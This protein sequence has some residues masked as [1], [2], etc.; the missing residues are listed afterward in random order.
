MGAPPHTTPP[1]PARRQ[2]SSAAHSRRPWSIDDL[3]VIAFALLGFGGGV[4]L[5]HFMTM[6]AITTS[7]LLA[8][9]L[10]ALTYR[11]LGGIQ[12]ASITIGSLKLGGALAALVGIAMLINHTM[13]AETTPPPAPVVPSPLHKAYHVTGTVVDDKG[14]QVTNLGVGDFIISPP[15]INPGFNGNFSVTFANGVD[16]DSKPLFPTLSINHGSLVSDT[17]SLKPATTD[18]LEIPLGTIHLH[19]PSAA[20]PAQARAPAAPDG[21]TASLVLAPE[22]KP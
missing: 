6:P 7:F 4:F 20:A 3:V 8:T 15:G 13:V 16:F 14:N 5:P 22:V 1:A 19:A 11:F 12:G 2:S 10:A 9:G 17:I 21:E 18:D